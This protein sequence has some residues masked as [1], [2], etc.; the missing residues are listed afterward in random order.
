[1]SAEEARALKRQKAVGQ[2]VTILD[3]ILE[4]R[5]LRLEVEEI[6]KR[7][8]SVADIADRAASQNKRIG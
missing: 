3:L 5:E 7:L 6:R 8:D 4:V 2:E 1:M